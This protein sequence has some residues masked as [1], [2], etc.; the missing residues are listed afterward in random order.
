[1]LVAMCVVLV[2]A[3]IWMVYSEVQTNKE[4]REKEELS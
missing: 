3:W 1:M 2:A 4:D